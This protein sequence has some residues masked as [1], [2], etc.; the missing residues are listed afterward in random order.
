MVTDLPWPVSGAQEERP[1]TMGWGKTGRVDGCG[2]LKRG[3]PE[4]PARS[5][6]E[7]REMR[8]CEKGEKGVKTASRPRLSFAVPQIPAPPPWPRS[9]PALD[10]HFCL[11]LLSLG[12]YLGPKVKLFNCRLA[13][14]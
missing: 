7:E 9:A 3:G 14:D 13:L 1:E 10:H 8:E 6:E 4:V 2:R 5:E 12:A 11:T